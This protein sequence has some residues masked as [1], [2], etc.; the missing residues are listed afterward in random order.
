MRLIL[1]YLE[2]R[3]YLTALLSFPTPPP[4]YNRFSKEPKFFYTFPKTPSLRPSVHLS[5]TL[6]FWLILIEIC[7]NANNMKMQVFHFMKYDLKGLRS[8][9]ILK[10]AFFRY[11]LLKNLT[12]SKRFRNEKW[13]HYYEGTNF[14]SNENDLKGHWR[15]YKAC[16]M[17]KSFWYIHL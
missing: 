12:L 2:N 5:S 17:I 1:H 13:Q 15:S 14:S 8:Y 7:F 16:F 3:N 10:S 6:I 11:T 9:L 4:R